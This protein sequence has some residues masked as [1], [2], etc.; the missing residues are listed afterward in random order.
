[1]EGGTLVHLKAA[2][3][4][5][6]CW[7]G[8][9]DPTPLEEPTEGCNFTVMHPRILP[10]NMPVPVVVSG[11]PPENRVGR[12]STSGATVTSWTIRKKPPPPTPSWLP[13]KTSPKP[14]MQPRARSPSGVCC[15]S[16]LSFH[17]LPARRMVK[18]S[19]SGIRG[20]IRICEPRCSRSL[21]TEPPFQVNLR[22]ERDIDLESS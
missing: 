15:A 16:K 3:P 1:M 9:G 18:P 22:I 6:A 14:G 19:P 12:C 20:F 13:S 11:V 21:G 17:P 2:G 5:T 8:R 4:R 10:G 7:S